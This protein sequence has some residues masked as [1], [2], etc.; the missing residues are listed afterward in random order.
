MPWVG[1][2]VTGGA[3]ANT[4][5]PLVEVHQVDLIAGRGAAARHEI[6]AGA[7]HHEVDAE[8]RDHPLCGPWALR[9]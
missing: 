9:T 6:G 3:G 5:G 8:G 7:Q 4:G 1:N 2:Q